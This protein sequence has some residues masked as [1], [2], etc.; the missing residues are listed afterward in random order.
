MGKIEAKKILSGADITKLESEI[1]DISKKLEDLKGSYTDTFKKLTEKEEEMTVFS[2]DRR[3]VVF[4]KLASERKTLKDK[5][6]EI[7]TT[8][9]KLIDNIKTKK[10][11]LEKVKISIGDKLSIKEKLSDI[12]IKNKQDEIIQIFFKDPEHLFEKGSVDSLFYNKHKDKIDAEVKRLKIGEWNSEGKKELVDSLIKN[13]VLNNTI[14]H[15]MSMLKKRYGDLYD[16]ELK[17]LSDDYKGK[18]VSRVIKGEAT[19]EEVNFVNENIDLRDKYEKNKETEKEKTIESLKKIIDR[20]EKDLPLN[21]KERDLKTANIDEYNKL[22]SEIPE[23]KKAKEQADKARAFEL[24]QKLLNMEIAKNSLTKDELENVNKYK[25]EYSAKIENDKKNLKE[26]DSKREAIAKILNEGSEKGG[27]LS[28]E[29]KLFMTEDGEPEKLREKLKEIGEREAKIVISKA[30]A[31]EKAKKDAIEAEG[32]KK[33]DAFNALR[34]EQRAEKRAMAMERY[35]GIVNKKIKEIE[36]RYGKGTT[37]AESE[38]ARLRNSALEKR[39]GRDDF[40]SENENYNGSHDRKMNRYN[41]NSEALREIYANKNY[42][43][44]LE[45]D[46]HKMSFNQKMELKAFNDQKETLTKN[47]SRIGPSGMDFVNLEE[48][49]AKLAKSSQEYSHSFKSKFF[50]SK[51]LA[52]IG[53]MFG[54]KWS[55]I[56]EGHHTAHAKHEMHHAQE[57]YEKIR[58]KL[59]QNFISEEHSVRKVWQQ[60]NTDIANGMEGL[61]RGV[62][63]EFINREYEKLDDLKHILEDSVKKPAFEK[64]AKWYKNTYWNWIK[65][66][67]VRTVAK[68]LTNALFL[69][70]VLAP[71]SV[72]GAGAVLGYKLTRAAIS[73]V[74]G[75]SAAAAVAG[76]FGGAKNAKGEFARFANM[77]DAEFR[78]HEDQ[79][80]NTIT[81]QIRENQKPNINQTIGNSLRT[82]HEDAIHQM[83]RR[84]NRVRKGEM[85]ARILVGGGTLYGLSQLDPDHIIVPGPNPEPTPLPVPNPDEIK[86]EG[87]FVMA[88]SRG[89]IQTFMNLKEKIISEYAKQPAFAGLNHDQIAEKLT[90]T[91]HFD[92]LTSRIL[93]AKDLDTFMDIAKDHGFWKP[94]G[95]HNANI[96]SGSV[97]AG[98]IVGMERAGE[99]IRMYINLPDGTHIPINSNFN[100]ALQ[101]HLKGVTMIDSDHLGNRVPSPNTNDLENIPKSS[102]E[103]FVDDGSGRLDDFEEGPQMAPAPSEDE[104][105]DALRD[106]QSPEQIINKGG[107]IDD[108]KSGLEE[109]YQNRFRAVHG[110]FFKKNPMDL[111]SEKA[112]YESLVKNGHTVFVEGDGVTPM[113]TGDFEK[114]K[115]DRATAFIVDGEKYY[116]KSH[117]G[118]DSS[119][120]ILEQDLVLAVDADSR[121]ITIRD[122]FEYQKLDHYKMVDEPYERYVRAQAE[123]STR[124]EQV[125]DNGTNQP[126]AS[127]PSAENLR[128]QEEA[129]L[130]QAGDAKYEKWIDQAFGRDRIIGGHVKGID[131]NAWDRIKNDKIEDFLNDTKDPDEIYGSSK[132]EDFFDTIREEVIKAKQSGY[133]V[134]IEKNE[135]VAH[136]V[137]RLADISAKIDGIKRVANSR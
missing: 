64:F 50:G 109:M 3:G 58:Q 32:K 10:T 97:P 76:I 99:D 126:G 95:W 112:I 116:L 121:P 27:V 41:R 26:K 54:F 104:V 130:K 119:S 9:K 80:V 67:R 38:I 107:S 35:Q 43:K 55:G 75:E 39:N 18:L 40:D 86:I 88:D 6:E 37:A 100:E 129:L 113:Q 122:Y 78:K 128:I 98:S 96:D 63:R 102:S 56:K 52:G 108:V 65:N 120:K 14:T 70:G 137:D 17:K 7:K 101:S 44:L 22:K 57:H 33:R 48:A 49:R 20:E 29:Q 53:N 31:E 123:A 136:F 118:I 85:W 69:G 30:E 46:P 115:F 16:A 133:S 60:E 89:F 83:Q 131:T 90:A 5:L 71:F 36:D 134:G 8:Q 74:A 61:L 87:T 132:E 28:D 11:L 79:F 94:E 34:P 114:I 21:I 93:G 127:R 73:G 117:G 51:V 42:Q 135:T 81:E 23:F 84:E 110:D 91:G 68:R 124:I 92:E 1:I 59:M 62:K 111:T 24:L 4:K 13:F 77:R 72:A 103:Q 125:S 45:M 19:P 47:L 15:E 106:I 66:E 12:E 25:D 82:N 2:G 105:N